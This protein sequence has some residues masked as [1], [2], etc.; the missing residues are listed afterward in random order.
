[1]S[2]QDDERRV[3]VTC[4]GHSYDEALLP[5]GGWALDVGA[6]GFK[7]SN[8][9]ARLGLNVIALEPD[10]SVSYDGCRNIQW[11]N[12]ALVG[13]PDVES[14][15]YAG[16]GD[17]S[18]NHLSE[19]RPEHATEFYHVQCITLANLMEAEMVQQFDIVK[20]DCEGSEYDILWNWPRHAAVQISVEFH[21]FLGLR[22]RESYYDELF[23]G[24]LRDYE[25]V[26]HEWRPLC[27]VNPIESYW[28]SL[29]I[30]RPEFR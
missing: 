20:L 3:L 16:W 1:M 27:A 10:R 9:L 4:D 21:D 19:T 25:I 18:G 12:V 15:M 5:D 29:F 24:P 8:H 23:A 6:R 17:G 2:L 28:D 13:D 7:F 26:R 11:R 22:P 14:S 30:L